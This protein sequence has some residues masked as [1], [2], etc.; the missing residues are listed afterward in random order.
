MEN[1]KWKMCYIQ[2]QFIWTKKEKKRREKIEER[3]SQ[4]HGCSVDHTLVSS[5]HSILL[6]A[7]NFEVFT[8]HF[9]TFIS[10]QLLFSSP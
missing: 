2:I 9:F 6:F 5:Q 8:L 10:P 4:R 3:K 7:A 1:G